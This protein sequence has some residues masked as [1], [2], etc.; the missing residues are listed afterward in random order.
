MPSFTFEEISELVEALKKVGFTSE[1]LKSMVSDSHDYFT[2]R[3]ILDVINGVAK[4]EWSECC[5]SYDDH[6]RIPNSP[7]GLE[8]KNFH[9]QKGELKLVPRKISLE[10][11]EYESDENDQE[12]RNKFLKDLLE[13]LDKSSI[14]GY[15]KINRFLPNPDSLSKF[16]VQKGAPTNKKSLCKLVLGVEVLDFLSKNKKFIPRAWKGKTIFFFG[17][18]YIDPDGKQYVSYLY[19][20]DGVKWDSYLYCLDDFKEDS[21]LIATANVNL[22]Y[23]E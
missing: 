11:I 9:N 6:P 21:F 19:S 22:D 23:K 17:T 20:F 2:L 15:L 13:D 4:I 5:I 7:E 1:Q 18:I 8:I 12:K 14:Y 3:Q 10:L 16:M